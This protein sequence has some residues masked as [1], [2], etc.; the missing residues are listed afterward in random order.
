MTRQSPNI[1]KNEKLAGKDNFLPKTRFCLRRFLSMTKKSE[2]KKS[3]N[4]TFASDK[5][6]KTSS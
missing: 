2:D 1:D 3:K 5:K 6:T 4:G